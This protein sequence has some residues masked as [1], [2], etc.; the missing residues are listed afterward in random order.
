VV[1]AGEGD[2][3]TARVGNPK[4][5]EAAAPQEAPT[6]D[7]A[8]M[9]P[10]AAS[11]LA[12]ASADLDGD[13]LPEIVAVAGYGG[14]PDRLG[15]ERIE[16]FIL[17]PDRPDSPIAWQAEL[18][19]ERAEPLQIQDVNN[20]GLPE[21]LI[22]TGLGAEGQTLH[23]LSW[24][25]EAYDFLRPH[26][27]FFDLRDSFGENAVRIQDANGDGIYEIIASHGPQASTAEVYEWDGSAYIHTRTIEEGA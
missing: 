17:E 5:F 9:L 21:A 13:G 6:P 20:D 12:Q 16:L 24:R 15:Y 8:L 26:G 22:T 4:A 2:E 23:I 10:E 11:V 14:A 27:G 19:G 1:F 7:I 18:T 25:G 3:I